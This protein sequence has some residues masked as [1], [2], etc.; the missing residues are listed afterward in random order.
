[1]YCCLRR[2]GIVET[3][4]AVCIDKLLHANFRLLKRFT[5]AVPRRAADHIVAV[6][7]G[8]ERDRSEEILLEFRAELF[9]LVQ[10][11][12][13]QFATLVQTIPDSVADLLM[14]FT[15]GNTFV[16]KI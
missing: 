10:G 9:Q 14:R 3:N 2:C 1:M 15:K 6:E 16:Y 5:H 4:A 11:Q 7:R 8:F 13:V 12:I